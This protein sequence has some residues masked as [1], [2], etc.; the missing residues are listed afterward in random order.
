MCFD[1]PPPVNQN[2]PITSFNISYTGDPFQTQT[3]TM[4]VPISP[5]IYPLSSMLC[6]NLI[7]LEENNNYTITV[8]AVNSIGNGTESAG[9]IELTDEAGEYKN[10]LFY[11]K[12]IIFTILVI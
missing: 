7:N 6:V 10:F 5:T 4:D 1:P 3:Q 9:V 2:G 8:E 12:T 11:G